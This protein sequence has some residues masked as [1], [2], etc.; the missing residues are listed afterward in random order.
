MFGTRG[1]GVPPPLAGGGGAKRRR[2][3][4]YRAALRR[5]VQA[6]FLDLLSLP[7]PAP[8]ALVLAGLRRARAGRAADRRVAPVVERVARHLVLVD[9]LPDLRARPGGE[10]RDLG[11][12]AVRGVLRDDRGLGPRR[13]L[14][15]A[16]PR[17]PGVVAA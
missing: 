2:G 9:V 6:A 5:R 4:L 16:E 7:P 1:R 17:D 13:G 8:G 3:R 15:P 12:A 10:R 14:V 11:D